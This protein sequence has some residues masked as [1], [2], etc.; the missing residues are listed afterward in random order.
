MANNLKK[1]MSRDENDRLPQ[2]SYVNRLPHQ[3]NT[4]TTRP[5]TVTDKNHKI[6]KILE[7]AKLS[8]K[9]RTM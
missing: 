7:Q 1:E 5:T 8:R 9:R 4:A 2:A 6:Y 3:V